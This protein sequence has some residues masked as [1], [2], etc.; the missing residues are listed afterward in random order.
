M[1]FFSSLKSLFSAPATPAL[2]P[3]AK[4]S[5]EN[6]EDRLTPATTSQDYV[7][8]VVLGIAHRDFDA[9][10]DQFLVDGLTSGQYKILDVAAIVEQSHDA[11]NFNINNL[12]SQLLLRT[13][14][15]G[16]RAYFSSLFKAGVS[17]QDARSI[18]TSSDEYFSLSGGTN[19]TFLNAVYADRLGRA[20]DS[21]GTSYFG[22]ELNNATLGTAAQRRQLVA[23]QIANSAEGADREARALYTAFLRRDADPAGEAYFGAF[24][25]NRV[26]EQEVIARMVGSQEYFDRSASS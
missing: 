26:S 19:D 2:R 3:S 24:L 11:I 13:P 14:D 17:I 12:Y 1:S 21:F 25:Y 16:G 5:L 7:S 23:I 20:P 22:A 4:L 9:A 6:L 10:K 18:I 8:S 15:A